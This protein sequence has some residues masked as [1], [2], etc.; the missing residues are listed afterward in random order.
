[1]SR[2]RGTFAALT[3]NEFDMCSDIV[4]AALPKTLE[5]KTQRTSFLKTI[6]PAAVAEVVNGVAG[7]VLPAG[8]AVAADF[9]LKIADHAQARIAMGYLAGMWNDYD[10]SN[11]KVRAGPMTIA[12]S[13][14][15]SLDGQTLVC[16]D[17]NW[18]IS[19]NGG[20]TWFPIVLNVCRWGSAS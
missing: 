9:A 20:E 10:C 13:G 1:V 18:E 2:Y 16:H 3:A 15:G 12:G 7:F 11:K 6:I 8:S 4:N 14:G 5:Y 17:E 19:F